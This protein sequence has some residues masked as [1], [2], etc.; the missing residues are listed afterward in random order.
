M[1][2]RI[3]KSTWSELVTSSIDP[4]CESQ[5]AAVQRCQTILA[6]AWMVRTFVKH[7]PEVKDYPEL[8]DL[9]RAVFDTCRAVESRVAEP[10]AYLEKLRA[11][12]PKLRDA[13][14]QFAR[15]APLASDHTNFKQAVIAMDGCVAALGEV[16]AQFPPP[17]PPPMPKSFRARVA[18]ATLPI[19][20]D[21]NPPD[22]ETHA[23]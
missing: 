18:S 6:N 15:D 11:R 22:D 2:P 14:V 3:S 23:D 17:A 20:G 4:K 8:M 12:W 1:P 21:A 9:V 10:P 7:S 5:V 16:L 19:P 13:A